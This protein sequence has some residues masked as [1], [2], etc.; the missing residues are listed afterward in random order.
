[1]SS[2]MVSSI[3]SPLEHEMLAGLLLA[4]G[5]TLFWGYAATVLLILAGGSWGWLPWAYLKAV[6]LLQSFF[7]SVYPRSKEVDQARWPQLIHKP[8]WT[9]LLRPHPERPAL[10]GFIHDET[11]SAKGSEKTV[12]LR[13]HWD[14]SATLIGAGLTAI[15]Q[16]DFSAAFTPAPTLCESLNGFSLHPD[17]SQLQKTVF[18]AGLVVRI[19]F[20]FPIRLAL[21]ATSFLWLFI[22]AAY[23]ACIT[24]NP[25]L[26]TWI[27]VK[28]SRIFCAGTGVIAEYTQKEHRPTGSGF[29]V[30]AHLTPNDAHILSADIPIA[31]GHSYLV[32]GQRHTGIIGLM[33]QMA[34]RIIPTLWLDRA[35]ADERRN[36]AENVL[37]AAKKPAPVLFFPEGYCSNNTQLLQF[38]R[39]IFVR[40]VDIHPIAIRQ[41]SRFGDGFWSEDLFKDYM[42]RLLTSWAVVYKIIYL[43][44]M[45]RE[46]NE[47]ASEFATRVHDTIADASEVQP[48]VFDGS[49]WYKKAE[50]VK[51]RESQQQALAQLLCS[52]IEDDKENTPCLLVAPPV[53]RTLSEELLVPRPKAH[54]PFAN[55]HSDQAPPPRRLSV[56]GGSGVLGCS[57]AMNIPEIIVTE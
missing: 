13:D 40:D 47:S 50:Q 29:A 45:R 27:A 20:L 7:P 9:R 23:A 46:V 41:D 10:F 4:Y 34:A 43:P 15:V 33:E 30:S 51:V 12:E 5:R 19:L 37:E 22:W 28:Y 35:S 25:R 16:D 32:T 1:D 39:A 11:S 52:N 44:K 56:T 57:H 18:A 3:C 54:A 38:R 53:D 6:G 49:F 2:S 21:V 31:T 14:A 55:K 17:W 24:I 42:I 48:A 26:R 36:F 8:S